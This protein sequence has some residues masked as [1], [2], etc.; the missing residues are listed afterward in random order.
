MSARKRFKRIC[1]SFG[2]PMLRSA[3]RGAKA[4][5]ADMARV[6]EQRVKPEELGDA[7]G[8]GGGGSMHE[9]GSMRGNV[10][11]VHVEHLVR[12]RVRRPLHHIHKEHVPDTG[13]HKV[14][15]NTLRINAPMVAV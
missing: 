9:R 2:S 14:A 6:T 7:G 8:G 13:S 5:A 4:A 10:V 12:L 11:H 1:G 15:R 3:R